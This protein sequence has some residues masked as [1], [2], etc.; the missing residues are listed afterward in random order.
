M[1]YMTIDF[2]LR[3][4]TKGYQQKSLSLSYCLLSLLL[5]YLI[6]F[7]L[8]CCDDGMVLWKMEFKLSNWCCVGE[9]DDKTYSICHMAVSLTSFVPAHVIHFKE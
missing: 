2:G 8:L 4:M 1:A 5:S 6:L 9:V 3:A 7:V